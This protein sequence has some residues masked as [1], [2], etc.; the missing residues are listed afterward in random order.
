MDG[1]GREDPS[2]MK[3]NQSDRR[4]FRRLPLLNLLYRP[5]RTSALVC[6][7][8][9]LAFVLFGGS[10]LTVSLQ[11]GLDSVANRFGADLIV[12]PLGYDTGMESILLKG[13]PSYFYLDR[14]YL[15]PISRTEG[16]QQISPQF[17]L[18]STSSD[19]CDLPVQLI[20]FDPA[21][22]FSIQPWIRES[23]RGELTG[24]AVLAGSDIEVGEEQTLTFFGQAYPVAARLERTGTGLDSAVYADMDTLRDMM[25]AAEEKGF[26]FLDGTDPD[27]VISSVLIRIG[28]GYDVDTVARN[29]R[30]QLDGLQIVKTQSMFTGIADSLGRISG[31]LRVFT[32]AFLLIS[33]A[34]LTLVFS[35]TA[36][37][38]K[39]EFAVLRILG[40]TRRQLSVVLLKESLFIGITGG[41]L[42]TALAALVIFPFSIAIGQQLG[43][44]YFMPGKLK[45]IQLL[46]TSLLTAFAVGP[47]AA[48]YS[49][50]RIS[51]T[52]TSLTLREGE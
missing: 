27:A 43:L 37:E 11:C 42:G 2:R 35:I 25:A 3:E 20:G 18:T 12:V 26:H 40:A 44:P 38:R 23:F 48:A 8:A 24:G 51:R 36:H 28:P 45:L 1:T 7:V 31:I 13:E 47:L 19:C 14:G 22:D 6:L 29:I 34:M 9:L 33:L 46:I 41:V 4:V 17:Y 49:A 10:V 21:S 30:F 15:D 32:A 50:W 16:V 39:K 52:D 5:F